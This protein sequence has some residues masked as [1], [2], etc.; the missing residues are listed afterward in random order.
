M[1]IRGVSVNQR[2]DMQIWL[3]QQNCTGIFLITSM[4]LKGKICILSF[5]KEM[6]YFAKGNYERQICLFLFVFWVVANILA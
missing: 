6:L 3:F 2:Q 4:G 1:T 5:K